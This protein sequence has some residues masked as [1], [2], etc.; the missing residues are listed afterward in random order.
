MLLL[1][2]LVAPIAGGLASIVL[3]RMLGFKRFTSGELVLGAVVFLASLVIQQPIQQLPILVAV[4]P[5]IVRNPG[6]AQAIVREFLE[7]LDPYTLVLVALWFGFTAGLVQTSFKYIFI[8]NRRYSDALNIG[9]GFGVAEAFYVAIVGFILLIIGLAGAGEA[10][11]HVYALSAA[12][13]FSATMFHVG[14]TLLLI[15]TIRLGRRIMG[16]TTVVAVHGAL[17]TLAA[18][19][20]LTRSPALLILTEI[21][22]LAAG[23]AITLKLYRKAIEEPIEEPLW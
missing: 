5:E 8:R 11:L 23:L 17:D 3:V 16:F 4:L 2:A 18:L 6:M 22:A 1:V 19:T 15:H 14:S 21:L 9:L 13:R 12:E 10:P 20:Q 7:S